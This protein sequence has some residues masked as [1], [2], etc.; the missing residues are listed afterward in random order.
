MNDMIYALLAG[1]IL[2]AGFAVGRR[3][4]RLR[5]VLAAV[6]LTVVAVLAV[7]GLGLDG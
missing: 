5:G 4:G 3:F 7:V 6:A 2:A 1:L